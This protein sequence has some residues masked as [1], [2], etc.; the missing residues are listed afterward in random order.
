MQWRW[1]MLAAV[2]A[3]ALQLWPGRLQAESGRTVLGV[4]TGRAA[5]DVAQAASQVL[6]DRPGDRI[7]LR[8]PQQLAELDA[9]A[10]RALVAQADS[11][12]AVA[13]FG[14]PGV[15]LREAAQALRR[16]GQKPQQ[17]FAFH[18][19]AGLSR[20]SFRGASGLASF[21]EADLARMGGEAPM[22]EALAER[23]ARDPLAR[24]WLALR[25]LWREGGPD[26]HG[27]H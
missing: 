6:A 18:S 3:L 17:L 24:D 15:R 16:Q 10:L 11:V 26:N 23:V 19:E 27:P 14:E 22:P 1:V 9:G 8:T 2:W 4:V 25:T 13:A 5:P 12:V 21:D 7:L 20:A